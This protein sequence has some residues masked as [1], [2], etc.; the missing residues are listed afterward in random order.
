MATEYQLV[1]VGPG[2]VGKSA[3]TIQ[4]VQKTFIADYDPTIEDSYRLST[5]VD[6][7]LCVLNILDTS[8]Q[9]EYSAMRDQ[10]WRT[11]EGFMCVYAI[12]NSQS[13]EVIGQYVDQIRRIK[14]VDDVLMILVG[15]KIDLA[16][17]RIVNRALGLS[18]ARNQQMGFIEISA[19][20]TEG[21]NEAFTQIV[22]NI[23]QWKDTRVHGKVIV[24]TRQCCQLL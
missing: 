6:G 7:R 23:Q 14:E 12:D 16:K 20:T 13:F 10:Y 15:N 17:R 11:G 3:L 9:E 22:R 2:G 18:F 8:R 4:Y 19:K 24:P 21:V 1:V 5:F